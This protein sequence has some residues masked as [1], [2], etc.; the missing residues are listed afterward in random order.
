MRKSL[1]MLAFL[2][3]SFLSFAQSPWVKLTMNDRVSFTVPDSL[4]KMDM[5]QVEVYTVM[6]KDSAVYTVTIID[7]VNFGLD[8]ATIQSMA[9]TDEFEE[10]FRGGFMGQLEGSEMKS[11]TRGKLQDH[12]TYLFDVDFKDEGSDAMSK[13]YVFSVFVGSKVYSFTYTADKPAESNKDKFFSSVKI[14]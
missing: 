9:D 10:Q 3:V 1:L 13:M 7:F 12:T 14:L 8:S 11:S 6:A 5:E 2:A 4:M